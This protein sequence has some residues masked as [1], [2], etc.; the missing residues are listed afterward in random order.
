MKATTAPKPPAPYRPGS[1][2]LETEAELQNMIFLLAE[3]TGSVDGA[4]LQM[5]AHDTMDILQK[6]DQ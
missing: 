3:A 4:V 6:A 1:L 2:V 5:F